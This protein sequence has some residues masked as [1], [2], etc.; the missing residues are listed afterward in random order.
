MTF[1]WLIFYLQ[2]KFSHVCPTS[3]RFFFLGALEESW[4]CILPCHRLS[5]VHVWFGQELV[6]LIAL[7]NPVKVLNNMIHPKSLKKFF[8]RLFDGLSSKILI[9]GIFKACISKIAYTRLENTKNENLLTTSHQKTRLKDFFKDFGCITSGSLQIPP[10][11][12]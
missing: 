12:R 5:P 9:F 11:Y 10:P 4:P 7:I 6:R 2:Q 1:F 3:V 8:S